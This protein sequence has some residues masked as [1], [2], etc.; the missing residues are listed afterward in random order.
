M[1]TAHRAGSTELE[2]LRLGLTRNPDHLARI[3]GKYFV[4]QF[5]RGGDQA[6]ELLTA[7]VPNSSELGA[8][9]RKVDK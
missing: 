8:M 4:V 3:D 1:D 6:G 2:D 5:H 7:F 9:L